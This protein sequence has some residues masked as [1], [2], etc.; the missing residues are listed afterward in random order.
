MFLAC[1]WFWSSSASPRGVAAWNSAE[2]IGGNPRYVQQ[3]TTFWR[4]SNESQAAED[5][6]DAR[7]QVWCKEQTK[8]Q[9]FFHCSSRWATPF[10]IFYLVPG[11]HKL[12]ALWK[13][14]R[15]LRSLRI[16]ECSILQPGTIYCRIYVFPEISV[17]IALS[18]RYLPFFVL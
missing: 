14:N 12:R 8:Q 5:S 15:P 18:A 6:T 11:L 10:G 2:Y 17:S 1:K 4:F 16:H 13:S 9:V 3:S 7:K